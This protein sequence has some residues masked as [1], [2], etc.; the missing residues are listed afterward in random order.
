MRWV[1]TDR[2]D[3]HEEHV[4][5]EDAG[6]ARVCGAEDPLEQRLVF[7]G[8]GLLQTVQGA[9]DVA[10]SDAGKRK[11]T[12]IALKIDNTDKSTPFL[13]VLFLFSAIMEQI[14]SLRT[15]VDHANFLKY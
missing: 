10:R 6:C 3:A 5:G 14:C 2:V 9:I 8:S 4:E 12:T 13:L 15:C 7:I 1:A 11:P